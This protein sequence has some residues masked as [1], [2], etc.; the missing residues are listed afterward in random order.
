MLLFGGGGQLFHFFLFT[1]IRSPKILFFFFTLPRLRF[2]APSNTLSREACGQHQAGSLVVVLLWGFFSRF[3]INRN[4]SLLVESIL[5]F[6]STIHSFVFRIV[7]SNLDLSLLQGVLLV[8]LS[9][10][11]FCQEMFF[12]S[13]SE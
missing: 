11:G 4:M 2:C 8:M 3:P 12:L 5:S 6:F 13:G 1:K 9:L 7:L 10:M